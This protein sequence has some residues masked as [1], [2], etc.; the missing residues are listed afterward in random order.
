MLQNTLL[1]FLVFIFS[2]MRFLEA[3]YIGSC[4]FL[5]ID[6]FLFTFIVINKKNTNIEKKKKERR[7]LF[8]SLLKSKIKIVK[9]GESVIMSL[10]VPSPEFF[11]EMTNDQ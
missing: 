8:N 7:E 3:D 6:V 1:L 9:E 4:L 2:L 11:Y 5:I 10:S